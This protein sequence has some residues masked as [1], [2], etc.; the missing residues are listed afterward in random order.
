MGREP[1]REDECSLAGG[2]GLGKGVLKDNLLQPQETL[3]AET[4]IALAAEERA[5]I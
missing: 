5:F 1:E 4:I 3:A 2:N